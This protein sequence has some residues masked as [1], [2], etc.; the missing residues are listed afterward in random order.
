[1]LTNFWLH[2]LFLFSLDVMLKSIMANN[3][4]P[5]QHRMTRGQEIY[6][7]LVFIV[8]WQIVLYSEI[9]VKTD[10]VTYCSTE[11]HAREGR[12]SHIDVALFAIA[13]FSW[14]GVIV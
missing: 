11:D 2:F 3:R 1:M 7:K 9:I 8:V 14:F 5:P 4:E 13:V 6:T 12:G 10:F